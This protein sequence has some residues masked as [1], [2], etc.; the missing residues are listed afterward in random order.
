M[1]SI[2]ASICYLLLLFP[3]L[4]A[5]PLP[6]ILLAYALVSLLLFGNL[7][8][9]GGS[10]LRGAAALPALLQLLPTLL[11]LLAVAAGM[12]AAA[13]AYALIF[14][15]L[16]LTVVGG[17]VAGFL[18]SESREGF[19]ANLHREVSRFLP[20][21][22]AVA[23]S[24]L[25]GLNGLVPTAATLA[26]ALPSFKQGE[27]DRASQSA[28]LFRTASVALFLIFLAPVRMPRGNVALGLILVLLL[29]WVV[30]GGP[31]PAKGGSFRRDY[32]G[33][34]GLLSSFLIYYGI[35]FRLFRL[36]RFYSQF[37]LP[38]SLVFDVGAHLGNRVRA[39]RSLD[40]R[41]I[42][43]EPQKS[44]ELVLRR[45]YGG[46]PR[47]ETV[48]EAVGAEAGE[49]ELRIAP[50]NPTMSTLST[51]F[52]SRI[53]EH[54]PEQNIRWDR[55]ET[56]RVSTLDELIRRYGEPDF[57]KI[58]VEGFEPEVL[59]GVS[60]PVPAL[61][62]EFLPAAKEGALECLHLLEELGEYEYNYSLRERMRLELNGWTDVAGM[63][64]R[65][66][67]MKPGE[68]SGDVYARLLR[69]RTR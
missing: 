64:S 7:F 55:K 9:E 17:V 27:G 63:R 10:R 41:V 32:R 1:W 29:L 48:A 44:C 69:S 30:E 25:Y 28:F 61:S 22:L 24:A 19:A 39:F 57:V 31:R 59:K 8:V 4:L 2:L 40:A 12:E 67:G 38:G 6:P 66:E 3:L 50:E 65:L 15:V 47:V 56:V 34:K 45:L 37:V 49:A 26:F 36:R 35:P 23:G 54:Y 33:I 5:G 18:L 21:P 58:D 43:L 53:R 13:G 62:F 11:F 14:G 16:T 60:R 20:L 68:S 46:D 42:A 51:T 52:I